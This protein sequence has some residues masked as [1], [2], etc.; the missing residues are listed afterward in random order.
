MFACK[1]PSGEWFKKLLRTQLY[2][3]IIQ[4]NLSFL[5]KP[6]RLTWGEHRA[7]TTGHHS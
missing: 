1:Y 4:G 2:L 7:H 6:R 5:A 3:E